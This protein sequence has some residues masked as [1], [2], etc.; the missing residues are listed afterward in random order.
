MLSFFAKKQ[1]TF[2]FSAL[3]LF[4]SN[5]LNAQEG[6]PYMVNYNLPG[7]VSSQNWG[8]EQGNNGEVFVLNRRDIYSF[9]GLQWESL[10]VK[11]NPIAI[12]FSNYLFFCTEQGVGYFNLNSDGQ[13][14]QTN[15]I[16]VTNDN[17]YYKFS[18]VDDG[19]LVVSPTTICK[20]STADSVLVDTVYHDVRNEVFIS[21]FFQ[22][23][24]KTYHVKNSSLIY[25]NKPD[26]GYEMLAGLPIGEDFT[27][28]F[29]HNDI[30]YFGTTHNKI[31]CFNGESLSQYKFADQEYANAS[32]LNGGVSV[33]N[34]L[35]ALSTLNG[36]CLLVDAAKGETVS[37]LNYQNGLPDDEVF[38]IG[39]DKTNGLWISHPMGV[40]RVDFSLPVKTMNYYRGLMG[41]VLSC[42]EHRGKLYVGTGEGLFFL[43]KHLKYKPVDVNIKTAKAKVIGQT[44][45]L[46]VNK[47]DI[48]Q[49]RK[50]FITKLFSRSETEPLSDGTT[51]SPKYNLTG[52]EQS[53]TFEYRQKRI[54]KLESASHSYKKVKGLTA[55]VRFLIEVKGQLY[56][57]TNFGL[58]RVNDNTASV[59]IPNLNIVFAQES[60]V[61][62][63]DILIG[64]TKGAYV[65]TSN[66]SLKSLIEQKESVVSITQLD[67]ST[68]ALS[69][70]FDVYTVSTNTGVKPEKVKMPE[71]ELG[72]PYV[73]R[74]QGKIM[75]F[76]KGGTYELNN[77]I[78]LK[79][80]SFPVSEDSN[81]YYFQQGF[82]WQHAN[83]SWQC[84]ANRS[85]DLNVDRQLLNIFENPT[86]L[87]VSNESKLYVIN[88]YTD[89][90]RI[91][92]QPNDSIKAPL[93]LFIKHIIDKDGNILSP[94]SINLNY[95]NNALKI[96]M[97]APSFVRK[98]A[99]I[100]Q[101]LVRGLT[102]SWTEWSN[103]PFIELPFIPSGN[104]V[105]LIRAKDLI[106]NY[107]GVVELPF[108][109][110]PPFW[111]TLWFYIACGVLIIFL[112]QVVIK[113]RE[114][115][116]KRDKLMLELKVKQRTR[117]IE[118]QK[119]EMEQQ[120]DQIFKQNDEITQSITY[121]RKIQ[122]AVMPSE[123]ILANSIGDYFIMFRPRDI[124]SG[125]FYW[126]SQK[127]N[128]VVVV[129]ADCTGHGVPGAFMSM[130]GVSFLNDIVNVEGIIHPDAILNNLRQKIKTAFD[131]TGRDTQ[132]QDGMDVAICTIDQSN[133]EL[134]YA[135]AYN[136]LYIIREGVLI[137][138]K[139]DKMPV[140]SYPRDKE[141]FTMHRVE[142]KPNDRLYMFSDGY[143]SQFGGP[144]RRKFMARPF[145]ELL[146]KISALPMA[147]QQTQLEDTM[148]MWQSSQDQVDDILVIGIQVR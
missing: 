34:G 39:T 47:Q 87:F 15:L 55:K 121:A 51:I 48:S 82:L 93:S 97:S 103:N 1:W 29:I 109:V 100:Y 88:A 27:F 124:V 120:R 75:V 102:T 8:F 5:S 41:N 71:G 3:L 132:R 131:K 45:T 70:E 18:K 126:I 53:S 130:M 80:D 6:N 139:A 58:Y 122:W 83:H 79:T 30:A 16:E 92:F 134:M 108:V 85:F 110:K 76:Y 40:T 113:L 43:D 117:T 11:G 64:T 129:A 141:K 36:G 105:V 63:G 42:N 96:K 94:K 136:P 116:L 89:I 20:I 148:D 95:A 86:F 13:H 68:Y 67:N 31:Y 60:E 50:G 74:V 138:Y 28:S 118:N 57:A 146:L 66:G 38:S 62:E 143:V 145:K 37:T 69:S 22:L 81:Y 78:L 19:L 2:I 52:D 61:Q 115:S 49:K 91:T 54:Y 33:G 9:D 73:R 32:I 72:S 12:A 98:G 140:G 14:V 133:Q 25:L 4:G 7:N 44:D 65:Y 107:S 21:D 26:S 35:I 24:G 127:D 90:Y 135:G 56:A 77:G 23:R 106:G 17:F 112:F 144:D 137:E 147:E 111:K 104:Y 46:A 123:D 114:K 10:N 99:V 128:L 119:Q 101:Y 125:D 59:V 142:L 84:W